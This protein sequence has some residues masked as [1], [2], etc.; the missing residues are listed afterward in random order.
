MP[1][2]WKI[3]FAK[4]KECNVFRDAFQITESFWRAD[5][6]DVYWREVMKALDRFADKYHD[7]ILAEELTKAIAT[8]LERRAAQIRE[9]RERYKSMIAETPERAFTTRDGKQVLNW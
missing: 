1:T 5:D 4:E 3:S 6:T 8:A 9:N 7:N 2:T